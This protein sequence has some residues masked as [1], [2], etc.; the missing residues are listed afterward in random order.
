MRKKGCDY[1]GVTGWRMSDRHCKQRGI[2]FRPQ[3]ACY[4]ALVMGFQ[5]GGYDEK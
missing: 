1:V 3:K 5:C 2:V 4:D